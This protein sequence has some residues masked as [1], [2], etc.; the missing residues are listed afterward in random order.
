MAMIT[1]MTRAIAWALSRMLRIPEDVPVAH[2]DLEH[3]HWDGTRRE[4]FTHQ[5]D[6]ETAP[7]RA[8]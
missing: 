6:P 1:Y 4:W 5:D 2:R 3:V 7:A 8:A